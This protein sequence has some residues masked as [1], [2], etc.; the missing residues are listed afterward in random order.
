MSHDDYC[1]FPSILGLHPALVL[2]LVNTRSV[3]VTTPGGSLHVPHFSRGL[4]AWC[5]SVN[6][7]GSD[8]IQL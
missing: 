1:M 5:G 3:Q 6:L 8:V 2:L 7:V 4:K